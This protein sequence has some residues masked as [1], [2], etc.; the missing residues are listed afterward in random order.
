MSNIYKVIT[1]DKDSIKNIYIF[2]GYDYKGKEDIKNTEEEKKFIRENEKTQKVKIIDDVFIYDDDSI[3]EIKRKIVKYCFNNEKCMEELYLCCRTKNVVS[4]YDAYQKLT[5]NGQYKLTYDVLCDYFKNIVNDESGPLDIKTINIEEKETYSYIDIINLNFDWNKEYMFFKPLD[6]KY[7][8]IDFLTNPFNVNKINK[9]INDNYRLLDINLDKNLIF[10]NN[11]HNNTIYCFLA[12]DLINNYNDKSN[13]FKDYIVKLY[14]PKLN[15]IDNDLINTN[16]KLINFREIKIK[17]MSNIFDDNYINNIKNIDLFYKVYNN[18]YI[19]KFYKS[20]GIKKI[21]LTI[22]YG[23]DFKVPLETLFKLI[24]STKIIPIIKYKSDGGK[25]TLYRFYSNKLTI[26]GKKVPYLFEE[27][28]P[29]P[30]SNIMKIN[31]SM[32]RD[33]SVSFYILCD[34]ENVENMI[35]EIARNGDIIIKISL[36]TP[37]QKNI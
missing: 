10:E 11:I 6:I 18:L 28:K 31:L 8:T 12:E 9:K 26:T 22:K 17:E 13:N 14:Y 15:N 32:M 7:K 30:I 16:E 33:S 29:N 25:G 3:Y 23:Y 19:K 24:N 20:R 21:E 34:D 37:Q 5:K 27:K 1:L 35:C 36:N 2:K 4:S